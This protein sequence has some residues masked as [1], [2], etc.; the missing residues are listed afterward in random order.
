MTKKARVEGPQFVLDGETFANG[1]VVEVP[2]HAL[3]RHPNT[4]QV[5]DEDDD[6]PD[7]DEVLD[8]GSYTVGE[9]EDEVGGMGDAELSRVLGKER[10][11]RD[12]DTAVEVIEEAME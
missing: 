7:E 5:V 6:A 8:P 10:D 9:L 2:E 3:E 11:N 1:D 4:L 12:R